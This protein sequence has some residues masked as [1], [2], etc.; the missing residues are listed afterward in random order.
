M[1]EKMILEFSEWQIF[2][3][4]IGFFAVKIAQ[5]VTGLKTSDKIELAEAFINKIV[6]RFISLIPIFKKAES[7][8]KPI[9]D[10]PKV[11]LELNNIHKSINSM[12]DEVLIQIS[13]INKRVDIIDTEIKDIKEEV[14]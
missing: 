3:M 8:D 10:V 13:N 2:W 7:I 12:R 9:I 6:D 5:S 1:G 4:V 11:N 14:F